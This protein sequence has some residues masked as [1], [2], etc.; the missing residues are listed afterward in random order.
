MDKVVHIYGFCIQGMAQAAYKVMA[1]FRVGIKE[2]VPLRDGG[3]L[4][5]RTSAGYGESIN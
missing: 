3:L 1:T 4:K 5:P 2:A